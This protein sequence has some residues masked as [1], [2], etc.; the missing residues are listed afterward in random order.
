MKNIF[1]TNKQATEK[2]SGLEARVAELE[3]DQVNATARI[4][5]LEAEVVTGTETIATLTGERDKAS[6]ELVTAQ[7]TIADQESTITA[8]N[9][10]LATFD[11]EVETK[12]QLGIANLGFKGEIPDSTTDH[13]KHITRA[14]FDAM[15]HS[16]RNAFIAAGGKLK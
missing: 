12:I 9:E 3:A 10:K 11:Q 7:A 4:E 6:A 13:S 16:A 1:M 5:E 15:D 14:E 8:A 2:I